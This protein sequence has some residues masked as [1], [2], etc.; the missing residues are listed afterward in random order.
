M[1]AGQRAWQRG[2][3]PPETAC[4]VLPRTQTSRVTGTGTGRSQQSLTLQAVVLFCCCVMTMTLLDRPGRA[5]E[6][7]R[8]GPIRSAAGPAKR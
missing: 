5:G 6:L 2:A 8:E 1:M 3:D 4:S 7:R